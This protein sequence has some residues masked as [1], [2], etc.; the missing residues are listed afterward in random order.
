MSTELVNTQNEL[1]SYLQNK[2]R[3]DYSAMNQFA[4]PPRI[5]IIQDNSKPPF[6]PPFNDGDVII[7]PQMLKIGDVET[8]FTFTPIY[9]FSNFIC[10]NPYSPNDSLPM[11]RESTFDP[12]SELA[13]KCQ[14][15]GYREPCPENPKKELTFNTVLNFLIRVEHEGAPEVPIAMVFRSTTFKFGQNLIGMFQ[16]R[17]GAPP[18]ACRFQ[19]ISTKYPHQNGFGHSLNFFNANVPYVDE[20]TFADYEYLHDGCKKLVESRQMVIDLGDTDLQDRPGEETK[21]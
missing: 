18:Y 7:V 20:K 9:F 21:F 6:K 13:R 3:Y 19:A 4:R 10:C 5:K 8:P 12:R 1:P 11:I 2:E 16:M 15:I 17:K 14:K